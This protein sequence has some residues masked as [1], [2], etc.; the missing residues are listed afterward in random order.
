M[1]S[2]QNGNPI[3]REDSLSSPPK[4]PTWRPMGPRDLVT[5]YNWAYTLTYNGVT[6]IGPFTG[7]LI[8]VI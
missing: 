5:T 1:K 3:S 8:T 2:L 6:P 7:I 4:T